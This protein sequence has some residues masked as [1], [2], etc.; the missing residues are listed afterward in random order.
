VSGYLLWRS[1]KQFLNLAGGV[2][3]AEGCAVELLSM[4][5]SETHLAAACD[6][7]ARPDILSAHGWL[8]DATARAAFL[9][10]AISPDARAVSGQPREETHFF[11]IPITDPRPAHITM[12]ETWPAIA[13]P[14]NRIQAACVAGTI[15]HLVMDQTWVELLVMPSLFIDGMAWSP[16]HDNWRLY[17]ILMTYLE[18]QAARRVPSG[19]TSLIAGG[20]PNTWLPFVADRV[21]GD[22]CRLVAKAIKQGG[23]RQVS[24]ALAKT[25][26]LKPEELE[27]I[28]LSESE[29]DAQAFS[30]V[31]PDRLTA[32]EAETARRS[33]EAVTH[34]LS[35]M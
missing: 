22:W 18:Y 19:T 27:A 35:S 15:T 2:G 14:S 33:A 25:C 4:P 11:T 21:L 6:L 29:M 31:P 24:S 34:Y 16:A 30:S 12:L 10:G 9:M 5:N 32:F 26:R 23:P 7:L 17:C 20:K 3:P 1:S 28:V 8:S 13:S